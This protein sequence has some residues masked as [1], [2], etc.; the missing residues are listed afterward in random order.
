MVYI[1]II[2]I[3]QHRNIKINFVKLIII[4]IRKCERKDDD[5]YDCNYFKLYDALQHST[6]PF[7]QHKS[8]IYEYIY[9]YLFEVSKLFFPIIQL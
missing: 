6:P 1:F 4:I 3:V 8:Y 7:K 9:G 5:L 2:Q